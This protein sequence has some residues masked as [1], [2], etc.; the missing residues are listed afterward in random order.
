FAVNSTVVENLLQAESWVPTEN[1]F[2]KRLAEF[3]TNL[4]VIFLPDLLHEWEIGVWKAIVMHLVR[5]LIAAKGGKV[6]EFDCG[7]SKRSPAGI[8]R[9]RNCRGRLLPVY[10]VLPKT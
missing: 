5:I 10:D 1:A 4:F 9:L 8:L 7:I 6:Q 2:A 3:L